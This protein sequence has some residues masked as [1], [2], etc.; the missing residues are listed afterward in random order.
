MN[1]F[2]IK[3]RFLLESL[4]GSEELTE[5]EKERIEII[6]FEYRNLPLFGCVA[7]INYSI[8]NTPY[9]KRL[10]FH[11]MGNRDSNNWYSYVLYP[12]IDDLEFPD[13]RGAI[14]YCNKES[15]P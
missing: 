15:N 13:L 4:L 3:E 9:S 7:I 10:E 6:K 11:L 2:P 8:K 12:I 14:D 5:D 1:S